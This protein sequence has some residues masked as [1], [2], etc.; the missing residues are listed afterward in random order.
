MV[1]KQKP[2]KDSRSKIEPLD[3]SLAKRFSTPN[4]KKFIDEGYFKGSGL[5]ET[6]VVEYKSRK[7]KKKK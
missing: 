4:L 6:I 5:A 2:S 3:W 1:K 7:D